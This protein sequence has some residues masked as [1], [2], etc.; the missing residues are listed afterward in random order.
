[1]LKWFAQVVE[2]HVHDIILV[3]VVLS[4]M[5][6]IYIYIY[7]YADEYLLC[8][9]WVQYILILSSQVLLIIKC[10]PTKMLIALNFSL[11]LLN[12][13]FHPTC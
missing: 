8:L 4:F 11:T 13:H 12:L 1:M 3:Q 6:M 10:W 7:I 2:L 5:L 9:I